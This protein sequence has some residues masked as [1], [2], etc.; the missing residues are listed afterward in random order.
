MSKALYDN[1]TKSIVEA[2]E[3]GDTKHPVMPWDRNA[4][5]AKTMPVNL[6]SK[7]PYRGINVLLLW[8][9]AFSNGYTSNVW[10][11]MKQWNEAGCKVNKGESATWICF[12]KTYEKEEEDDN[13][14]TV[15]RRGA[16]AKGYKVF[17]AD[18][19]E[20]YDGIHLTSNE[21]A[22]MDHVEEFVE[23]TGA[24]IMTVDGRAFYAPSL[25]LINIPARDTFKDTEGY[26]GVLLH[27][28]THWTGA[29]HR[30]D[31]QKDT[32]RFGDEAYAFEELVAELGAAFLCA[33]LGITKQPREDHADYINNWLRVL[34]DD[35]YAI[36]KA[37]S[38][39]QRAAD[40]LVDLQSE[41]SEEGAEAA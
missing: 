37:A 38:E 7:K 23:N 4:A 3:N 39:A 5:M 1:V 27:E 28:L 17:N 25:D 6:K 13:G 35:S 31:R 40:Y 21:I 14:D 41:E 8:S 11:T 10:A 29:K 33:K 30:L 20:G 19:V 16:T 9:A 32:S 18:Q 15:K 36:F 22:T 26:Y 2:I 24:E 12:F 34:K